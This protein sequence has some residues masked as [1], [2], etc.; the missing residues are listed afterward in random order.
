[1]IRPTMR[2]LVLT[3]FVYLFVFCSVVLATDSTIS[4]TVDL[5]TAF[6]SSLC[7]S[8]ITLLGV[9]I[10]SKFGGNK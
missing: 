1:M 7:G 3:V 8:V 4:T 6:L 10:K 9:W 5:L 2:M